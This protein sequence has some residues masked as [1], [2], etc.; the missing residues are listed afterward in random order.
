MKMLITIKHNNKIFTGIDP[1]SEDGKELLYHYKVPESVVN[2]AILD[3]TLENVVIQRKA[4]YS[5]ESDP[6]FLE[7]Q[8]DLSP[9]SEKAWRDKVAEIKAR[10]PLPTTT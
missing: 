7:W 1:E 5:S 4:A 6:L 10:Y 3:H 8:F 9:E 2:S